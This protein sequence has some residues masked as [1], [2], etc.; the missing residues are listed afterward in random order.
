MKMNSDDS[1]EVKAWGKNKNCKRE[2]KGPKYY[3]HKYMIIP[4]NN[5]RPPEFKENIIEYDQW[6]YQPQIIDQLNKKRGCAG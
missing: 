6:S 4:F 1:P 5:P 3:L 2:T